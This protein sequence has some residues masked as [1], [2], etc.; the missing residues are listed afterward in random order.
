MDV[1][2]R[3]H[4]DLDAWKKSMDLVD[5][6]YKVTKSF[7]NEELYSLTN[8]MRRAA[9]SIPS[10]IAEGAARGSKNDFIRFLYIALGSLSEL[11]TQV[12]IANRLGYLT[13]PNNLLNDIGIIRKLINGLIYSLKRDGGKN[14]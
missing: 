14:G 1:K 12:I 2:M 4:K 10:N 3:S 8:Q 13:N 11:E 7:P 6:I 9:I 5:G